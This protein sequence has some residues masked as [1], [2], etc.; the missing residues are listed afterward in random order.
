MKHV[1]QKNHRIEI[2]LKISVTTKREN[3][4]NTKGRKSK[5]TNADRPEHQTER[6]NITAARTASVAKITK[7]HFEKKVLTPQKDTK[8][9]K[10]NLGSS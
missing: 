2:G 1:Q 3:V 8:I 5:A 10:S 9:T 6:D 4:R 7:R